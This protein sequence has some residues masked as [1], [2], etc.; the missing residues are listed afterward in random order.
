MTHPTLF[1]IKIFKIRFE[2][3]NQRKTNAKNQSDRGANR[4]DMQVNVNTELLEAIIISHVDKNE[5][6]KALYIY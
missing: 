2:P 5:I 1:Q 6:N 4:Q 3:Q